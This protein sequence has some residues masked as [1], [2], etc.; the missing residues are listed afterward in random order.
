MKGRF[1]KRRLLSALEKKDLEDK[2]D[3]IKVYPK[4]DWEVATWELWAEPVRGKEA[5]I[6]FTQH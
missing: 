4:Q 5:N 3:K 6:H 2:G 1:C